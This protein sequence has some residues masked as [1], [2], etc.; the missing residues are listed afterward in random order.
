MSRPIPR[1][2]APLCACGCGDRTSTVRTQ[3]ILGHRPMLADKMFIWQRSRINL[4]TGCVEWT[5][6]AY[7]NGY[8]YIRRGREQTARMAHRAAYETFVGPI[9]E[10]LTLDHLCRNRICINPDHLEPVTRGENALRGGGLAIAMANYR[11]RTHCVHGH[12]F[13]PENTYV[14]PVNR[15][16]ACKTCQRTAALRWYHANKGTA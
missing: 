13:T 6:Q 16:R 2:N 9:P 1:G 5:G 10:G 12:E 8:G 14:H 3:F 11:A 4:E 7:P 15:K